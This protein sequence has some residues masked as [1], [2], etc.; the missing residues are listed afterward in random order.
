MSVQRT[1]SPVPERRKR[2]SWTVVVR[3]TNAS[4]EVRVTTKTGDEDQCCWR[5]Q[6]LFFLKDSHQKLKRCIGNVDEQ[7]FNQQRLLVR[8]LE[9]HQ[10]TTSTTEHQSR[11]R[12]DVNRCIIVARATWYTATF[13]TWK[14]T[15]PSFD[16]WL[17]YHQMMM[18]AHWSWNRHGTS[19]KATPSLH[20]SF[21]QTNSTK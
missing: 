17:T 13:S 18:S 21:T 20:R 8:R 19:L 6:L 4:E 11:L 2:G 15:S 9:S 5:Q 1:L 10:S 7:H 14:Y 3:R 16:F 12:Q